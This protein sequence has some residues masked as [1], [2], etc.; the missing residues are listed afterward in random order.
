MILTILTPRET[1]NFFIKWLEL[2]TAMGN[3]VIMHGHAPIVLALAPGKPALFDVIDGE[4]VSVMV[5]YGIAEIDREN[6]RLIIT[7]ST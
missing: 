6:V 3:R 4:R 1:K 5:H 7:E 2:N